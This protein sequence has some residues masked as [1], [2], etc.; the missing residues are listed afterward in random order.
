MLQTN[1]YFRPQDSKVKIIILANMSKQAVA[2]ALVDFRP[3]LEQKAQIVSEID[4][5]ALTRS[6]AQHLPGADLAIV[7]GGDG[8]MLAQAR[9]MID[10]KAA[11]LGINFGKVGFLAEF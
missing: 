9:A 1:D 3:W 7:L 2:D 4:T 8:T 11:L 6:R 5:A 10:H